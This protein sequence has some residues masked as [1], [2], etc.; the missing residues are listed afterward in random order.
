MIKLSYQMRAMMAAG[1]V[2]A[3]V[4]LM[5]IMWYG[6]RVS[7]TG[8][9]DRTHSLLTWIGAFVPLFFIGWASLVFTRILLAAAKAEKG[10]KAA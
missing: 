5:G 7:S 1:S 3:C 6:G 4:A 10:G 8:G 2:G 9:V